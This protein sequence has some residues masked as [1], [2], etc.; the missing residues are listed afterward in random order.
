VL[1]TAVIPLPVNEE[2]WLKILGAPTGG[3]RVAAKNWR[4]FLRQGPITVSARRG[5][6]LFRASNDYRTAEFLS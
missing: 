6:P 1:C 4:S 5:G 3:I 2:A